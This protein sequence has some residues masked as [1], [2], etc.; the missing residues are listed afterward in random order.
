MK[1]YFEKGS[2]GYDVLRHI[3]VEYDDETKE[4]SIFNDTDRRLIAKNIKAT[5]ECFSYEIIDF[6]GTTTMISTCLCDTK[7]DDDY[8]IGNYNDVVDKGLTW[9]LYNS[10]PPTDTAIR[11]QCL[12]M[13]IAL[14]N[15]EIILSEEEKEFLYKTF[16]NYDNA[17]ESGF[18]KDWGD[19]EYLKAVILIMCSKYMN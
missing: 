13:S 6:D 19:F 2:N 14:I 18:A 1:H 4:L 9:M 17:D 15:T 8:N 3:M 5:R 10:V 12:A 16:Y 7:K 11:E